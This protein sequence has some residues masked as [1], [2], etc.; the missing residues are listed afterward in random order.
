MLEAK[1]PP[2]TP[3]SAAITRNI[4][5]GVPGSL[6]ASPSSAAGMTSSSALTVVNVAPPNLAGPKV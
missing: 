6:T 5:Y 4:Q 1:L 2:P 3:A